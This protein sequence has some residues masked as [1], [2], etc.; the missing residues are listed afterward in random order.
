MP[1]TNWLLYLK[2][3]DESK[4]SGPVGLVWAAAYIPQLRLTFVIEVV[5][6]GNA[7]V[8]PPTKLPR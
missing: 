8:G 2:Y 6:P 1:E 5:K 4:G 7:V 3:K